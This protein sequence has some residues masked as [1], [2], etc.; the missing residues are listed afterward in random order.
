LGVYDAG[1]R[2]VLLIF[3]RDEAINYMKTPGG[4]VPGHNSTGPAHFAFR[5]AAD[6]YGRWKLHLEARKIDIVSEVDWGA[7]GKSLYF[8]DP[9]GNVVELA[10]PRLW[11]NAG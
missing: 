11:P 8:N 5:I 9:D 7:R 6:S 4:V 10:T 1:D 3:L 2:S